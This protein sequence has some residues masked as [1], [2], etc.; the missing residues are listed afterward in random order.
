M[1]SSRL[2]MLL[3]LVL[4]LNDSTVV[5]KPTPSPVVIAADATATPPATV[6]TPAPTAAS[7]SAA[8][9]DPTATAGPTPVPIH[10]AQVNSD[11][12][13]VTDNLVCPD[14]VA[15]RINAVY[16]KNKKVFISCMEKS[17]YQIFP[18]SGKVPTAQDSTL[19]VQ[20][21]ECMGV[22][23]AVALANLP[24]CSLGD[25]PIKAVVETLLKISV[26]MADGAP[27][28]S[29][30]EFHALMAWR[31]D[32]NAAQAVGLPYDGDSELYALFK[33]ALWRALTNTNV[34]VLA[35]LTIVYGDASTQTFADASSS[36]LAG[37]AASVHASSASGSGAAA[38]KVATIT[39]PPPATSN[40]T[41]SS[42]ATRPLAL[43]RLMMGVMTLSVM[44]LALTQKA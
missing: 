25:M 32:V 2:L 33:K 37:A 11:T 18:Y 21:P 42:S 12:F 39:A 1:A 40:A 7:D 36:A 9:A 30:V 28:P 35:D 22:I 19:M 5:A 26:D 6:E 13:R 29:A 31:R 20:T 4:L 44:L 34:K 27:A 38:T 8:A 16:M 24:A 15:D 10:T 41:T 23:T 14:L 3:F 17:G 43:S